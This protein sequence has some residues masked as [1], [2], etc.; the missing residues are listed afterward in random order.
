MRSAFVSVAFALCGAFSSASLAQAQTS[1]EAE[2]LTDAQRAALESVIREY[3]LEN[4]EVIE[5]AIFVLQDRRAAERVER[6]RAAIAAHHDELFG[7]PRDFAVG[8]PDAPVQIVEFFDYNCSYCRRAAPWVRQTLD[9]YGD[10]VRFVFKETPIFADT[11]ESSRIGAQ[12]ALAAAELDPD[13]YLDLHFELMSSSGTIPQS[14]VRQIAESVDLN[15]R[16]LQGVMDDPE[17]QGQLDDTVDLLYQIGAN[18][19]PAFIVNGEMVPGAN[20][21]R[22][23]ELLA[24]GLAIAS[25][26]V[27]E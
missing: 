12:A 10:Q 4:P 19:T 24:S 26:D 13:K 23:D 8:P 3:L 20:I 6:E 7:N 22:L 21:A 15:W 27:G 17:T 14:Q 1:P 9:T 18:G 25:S 2:A 11:S 5:E 16:R